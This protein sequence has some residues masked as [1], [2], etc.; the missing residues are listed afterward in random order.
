MPT[1]RTLLLAGVALLVAACLAPS[2]YSADVPSSDTLQQLQNAYSL[3]FGAFERNRAF[4]AK[5]DEENFP[6]AAVLFR[7][8]SRSAQIQYTNLVDAIRML[9]FP[10]QATIESPY[11]E[12]TKDNLQ[13]ALNKAEA[14]DKDNSYATYI[15]RAKTEGNPYGA[16]VLDNLRQQESQN[17]RLFKAAL[18]NLDLLRRP[19]PGYYV[20]ASNGY[21]SPAI[22]SAHCTGSDWE[23]I[24]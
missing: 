6:G 21:V 16:K 13:T 18:K 3:Q 5:A 11:L 24:K 1:L 19:S 17:V 15:K 9:G 2:I 4:A 23:S 7:A 12:S 14:V 10:P 8:V 22:D 20:C